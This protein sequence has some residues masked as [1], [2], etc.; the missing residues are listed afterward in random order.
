M[1]KKISFFILLPSMMFGCDCLDSIK[2]RYASYIDYFNRCP[3]EPK[4][5]YYESKCAW[6]DAV[7]LVYPDLIMFLEERNNLESS[8]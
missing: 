7:L 1:L 3:P 4:E 5:L 8:Y 6:R 2:D